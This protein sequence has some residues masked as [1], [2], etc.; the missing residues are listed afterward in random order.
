MEAAVPAPVTT[1]PP[2]TTPATPAPEAK[3]I[4]S[5]A[6]VAGPVVGGCVLVAA[7]GYWISKRRSAQGVAGKDETFG[8]ARGNGDGR[9]RDGGTPREAW[10]AN[11]SARAQAQLN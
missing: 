2:A 8:E 4:A 7:V 6:W 10:A 9:D 3:S 5:L 1:A 11:G